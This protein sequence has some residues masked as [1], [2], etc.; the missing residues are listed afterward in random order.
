MRQEK[1]EVEGTRRIQNLD[2]LFQIRSFAGIGSPL[3]AKGEVKEQLGGASGLSHRVVLPIRTEVLGPPS[4][5]LLSLVVKL[6]HL[7]YELFIAFAPNEEC[8]A[9]NEKNH[10]HPGHNQKIHER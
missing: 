8:C 3:T 2:R 6:F 5:L 7:S 4:L 10:E 9:D 1:G